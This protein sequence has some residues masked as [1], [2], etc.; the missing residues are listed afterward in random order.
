M[1][2]TNTKQQVT[3]TNTRPQAPT[4]L[5]QIWQMSFSFTPARVLTTALQ[6]GLFSHL[7]AGHSTAAGV[8]AAAGS[9]E[10]GTRM[11]L[12]TLTSFGLLTKAGGR[13]ELTPHARQYLVRESADYV[14][15]LAESGALLDSWSHLTEC[16]RTGKP[17]RRVEERQM[18]EEFFPMLVRTLHVL[19][20]EPA[21]RTAE[22]LG[23]GSDAKGLRVLDVAC[24][25]GVW[26]IAFAEADP[27]TRVTAQDFPGVLPT[28]REYVERHG[29]S[30]RFDYLAGDLK[31]VDF[32]EAQ[33]DVALLGNIVHS[34]GERSSREL[35]RKLRRALRAGGRVV[36]IDMIPNDARTA[37]P[38]ALAF[39]LNMLLNTEVGD[40]Y[41]RAEYTEWLNEA[42]FPRVETA[43][44]GSHSPVI[45]GHAD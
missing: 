1:T 7:A 14:G 35:F 37:P 22:A 39:A 17:F 16:V 36:V 3:E 5:E 45:I 11:I 38:H 34:E 12:D 23:A 18:A 4:P 21:R 40:T 2:D 9:S 41:T 42:G 20:R 10:R 15:G 19:H 43:D 6:L 29:L 30:E 31:E 26:G 33:Y 13:Y 32:G 28:T 44:I 27:Q 25:T 24:G 8:A